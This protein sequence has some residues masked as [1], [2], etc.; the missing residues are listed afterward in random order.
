VPER[1]DAQWQRRL[2]LVSPSALLVV[3]MPCCARLQSLLL[4]LTTSAALMARSA[5][6]MVSGADAAVQIE[7]GAIELNRQAGVLVDVG[8][9]VAISGSCRLNRNGGAGVL[10]RG[11]ASR[12]LLDYCCVERNEGDGVSVTMTTAAGARTHDATALNA[13]SAGR[14]DPLQQM[15]GWMPIPHRR[16]VAGRGGGQGGAGDAV[17]QISESKITGNLGAGVRVKQPAATCKIRSSHIEHGGGHGACAE[18][19]GELKIFDSRIEGNRDSGVCAHGRGARCLLASTSIVS[20]G[21][22]ASAEGGEVKMFSCKMGRNRAGEVETA[23]G[24]RVVEQKS[25]DGDGQWVETRDGV[26]P[27][28]NVELP[29][30]AQ[31]REKLK[32]NTLRTW[33]GF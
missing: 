9:H 13:L 26:P 24:G 25:C 5:H 22:G 6:S 30:L 14:S 27:A 17:A 31:L 1:D 20:N 15:K 18:N 3:G 23:H 21:L 16:I 19:G 32:T 2:R 4:Q 28:C 10:V 7:G 8:A 12:L 33:H 29:W 11:L